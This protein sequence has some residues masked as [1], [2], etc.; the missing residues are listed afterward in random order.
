MTFADTLYPEIKHTNST[1]F[2]HFLSDFSIKLNDIFQNRPEMERLSIL[3]RLPP[4]LLEE[5]MAMNPLSVNIPV[6][7]GGRGAEMHENLA[8]LAACSYQSLA[9]SLTFGING[10]LFLQPFAKYGQDSVKQ[11]VFDRFLQQKAMGGLMITEPDFGTDAFGMQTAFRKKNGSYHIN[12]TKHWAGLTGMANFWLLTARGRNEHNKL[13]RDVDFFLCDV[14][15]T[16]QK[17]VVEEYFE[18]LG[19]YQIPYGR[20]I[21]DVHV[22]ENHRLIPRSTGIHM[23]LDLLHTSRLHFPGMGLGFVKRMLD[24]ALQHARQRSVGPRRLTDYDQVQ[25]RLARLQ[26]AFTIISSLGTAA[27]KIVAL[28]DDRAPF[29]LEANVMKTVTSDLMQESAQSLLQLVGAKGYKLNHIAGSATVDSRPFQIFEGSND[30]L[31]AQ[32]SE[33]VIRMMKNLKENTL[34]RFLRS[35]EVSK[36][37]VEQ[38]KN[39]FNFEID[40]NL[41]QRKLVELGKIISRLVAMEYVI[42]NAETGFRTDLINN[43]VEI[44]H[45]EITA[46]VT[47]FK[48]FQLS[49]VVEDY[50]EGTGW[51]GIMH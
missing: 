11:Q 15:S 7:F 10:A 31:Y 47:S 12:G 25:E 5:I 13:E 44:L 3:R 1:S 40:S 22:P 50:E 17:I 20:N 14:D 46:M 21:I 43:A 48:H 42:R 8:F 36:L 2:P 27:S 4:D 45:Q 37:A 38:F 51:P 28:H 18:N 24:E 6:E 16:G 32:I 23:M 9:L 39:L 33:S 26:A 30:I 35:F 49:T 19:L 41:P 29:R 34:Q